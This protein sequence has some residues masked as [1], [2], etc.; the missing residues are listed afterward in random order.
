MLFRSKMLADMGFTLLAT[1]GTYQELQRNDIPATRIPKLAEGRPN[2]KDY[3]KNGQVK[4]IINTP[5]NKG[6]QTDEGRIR[7]MAVLH[8]IPMITT[9]PGAVAAARAIASL[10]ADAWSVKPL[11][12]YFHW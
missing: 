11:Q 3:I 12:E 2:I 7:A 6:P 4:M 10:R 5:T 9:I 1:A 8:K